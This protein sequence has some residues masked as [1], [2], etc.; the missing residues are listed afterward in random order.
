[1]V[2]RDAV[3]RE[4]PASFWLLL[5]VVSLALFCAI[6]LAVGY[7][8]AYSY[9]SVASFEFWQFAKYPPDLAFLTWALPRRCSVL[10]WCGGDA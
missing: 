9:A 1:V 10:P 6:R 4:Q 2:G 3:R 5:S 8:N 7:G